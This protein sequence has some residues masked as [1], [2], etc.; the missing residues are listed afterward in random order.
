MIDPLLSLALA[1]QSNKGAHALLIGSGVSRSAGIPTGW[2]VVLDLIRTLAAM[3]RENC[4]PDPAAWYQKVFDDEPGYDKL[5]NAVAGLPAERSP[6]LKSYFEPTDE[7][8]ERGLKIPTDA[9][10]AIARLVAAGH[11]RVIIT[12]NFDRLLEQSLQVLG[13]IPTV[14][15]TSF[16]PVL[17][18]QVR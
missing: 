9:H 18:R 12:T 8:R 7:E 10:K 11:I 14:I 5:L 4:E 6:L 1:M 17:S 13:I 16:G 3:K 2:E 15:S